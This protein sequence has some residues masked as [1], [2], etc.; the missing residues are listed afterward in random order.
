MII[1][2]EAAHANKYYRTGVEEACWQVIQALKKII[3]QRNVK[4]VLYSNKPLVG[5]LEDLPINWSVKVLKWPLTKGWSQVRLSIDF[6][7]HPPDIFFAPGQLVPLICPK[8]T[9]SIIHDSAFKVF[10]SAYGLLSRIYLNWM[11]W[12]IV[13]K[14]GLIITPSEFSKRELTKYYNFNK[15]QIIVAPWGYDAAKFKQLTPNQQILTKYKLTKP[16]IM[17]V[18]RLEEKKNTQRIVQ[19]FNLIRRNHDLQLLLAGAP[20]VGYEKVRQEIIN[21][22]YKNDIVVPGWV[23]DDLPQLLNQAKVFV[24]PSLYEGFGLPV[25]EAMACGCPVVSSGSQALLEVGGDGMDYV[26]Y[27]DVE[28]ITANLKRL[29]NDESY[30]QKQISYGLNRVKQFSWHKTGEK[31]WSILAKI[32]AIF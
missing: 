31:V 29:L 4:V 2:I 3:S 26:D 9:I 11:N 30:R 27:K 5:E 1:G 8:K 7:F 12:L 19:A 14:S 20:G 28:D 21:S 17:S 22:P 18:G 13:K 32:T 16:F 10:P 6:F 24:F 25:L 23:D 15:D